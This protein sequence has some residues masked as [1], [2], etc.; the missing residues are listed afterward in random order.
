MSAKSLKLALL[1]AAQSAGAFRLVRDSRWRQRRLL[2]L[3]YHGISLDEEHEWSPSYYMSLDM[4]EARMRM[5]RDGGYSVLPLD[6]ALVKQGEGTLPPRSVALT[7]DDGSADFPMRAFPV[8]ERFGFP[9]TVY[10]TTFYCGHPKPVF[11]VFVS[12]V[13]WKARNRGRL[14]KQLIG[15]AGHWE[16][17]S[18]EGRMRAVAD[19]RKYAETRQL[20]TPEKD[21]LAEQLASTL[22]LNYEELVRRRLLQIMSPREV[23][24]LSAA[25]VR[26]EL[27]THRHRTPHVRDLFEREIRENRESIRSLTQRPPV[28]F[29]YPS[30]LYEHLFLDWLRADGVASA[31]TCESGI[32]SPADNPLL[33]PRVVDGGQLSELEFE[34]WTTGFAQFLPRRVAHKPTK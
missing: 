25:G 7:F 16:I 27:H 1:R 18:T 5:L 11:G 9:A 34:G 10:L 12:Y 8:L 3:C 23:E 28:H 19:L 2:I 33:L 14:S 15:E 24:S 22:G 13:I 20:S 29:C 30:G 6:E 4:F 26:F 31:T 21:A 32:A 17:G